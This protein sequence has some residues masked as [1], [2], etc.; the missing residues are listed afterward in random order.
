MKVSEV[1]S[2]YQG[3]TKDLTE[4]TRKLGFAIA[5]ICWFFK[6]EETTFPDLILLSLAF[7]VL[8]LVLDVTQSL[9]AAVRR[10]RFARG[11]EE[12]RWAAKEN[13]DEVDSNDFEVEIPATLDQP[14]FVLFVL[15]L[16]ALALAATFLIS[17]FV[18]RLA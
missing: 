4:Q 6:S 2:Q 10:R 11:E 13:W 9:A 3:Y 16:I 12:K 8:F 17:E 14:V 7:V 15:K 18:V 1:W 5:A